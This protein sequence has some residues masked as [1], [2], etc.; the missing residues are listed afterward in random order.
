MKTCGQCGQTKDDEFFSY[1]KPCLSLH[2]KCNSCL[3][4]ENAERNRLYRER[5]REAINARLREKRQSGAGRY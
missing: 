4:G 3:R 1:L 5:N 2:H